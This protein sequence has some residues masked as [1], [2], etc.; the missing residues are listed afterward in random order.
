MTD[1][2]D[3][4]IYFVKNTIELLTLPVAKL[5]LKAC[6]QVWQRYPKESPCSLI[7]HDM[8]LKDVLN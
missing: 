2:Y 7:N 3:D 4:R 6:R 8:K 5:I 1:V